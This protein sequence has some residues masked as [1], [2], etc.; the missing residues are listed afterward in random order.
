MGF[1]RHT[2]R[3]RSCSIGESDAHAHTFSDPNRDSYGDCN[4][5]NNTNSYTNSYSTAYC[6]AQ[7]DSAAASDAAPA[8]VVRRSSKTVVEDLV[9]TLDTNFTNSHEMS[10][11][12]AKAL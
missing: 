1:Q 6:Y 11:R 4:G 10:S 7:S 3:R 9:V 8:P 12:L 5:H 2:Y